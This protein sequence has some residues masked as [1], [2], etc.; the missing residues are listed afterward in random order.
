[1][2]CSKC[3]QKLTQW[4]NFCPNCGFK[5]DIQS[6]RGLKNIDSEL[7]YEIKPM[8][9]KDTA[10]LQSIIISLFLIPFIMAFTLT[11]PMGIV[12]FILGA[13]FESSGFGAIGVLATTLF[14]FIIIFQYLLCF[15]NQSRRQMKKQFTEFIMAR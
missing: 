9:L 4:D 15:I 11:I 10:I 13:L 7:L 6:V 12:L 5:V 1:M 14:S 8:F 3:N 2:N